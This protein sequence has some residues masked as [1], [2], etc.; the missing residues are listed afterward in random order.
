[1][2]IVGI[3][4]A[5]LRSFL[6]WNYMHILASLLFGCSFLAFGFALYFFGQWGGGDAKLLAA[7]AFLLPTT[8]KFFSK[9]LI[10]PFPLSYL[11]N[12]LYVGAGYMILY[13]FVI[14]LM[15]K[16]VITAFK[17]DVK[18]SSNFLLL[19]V[20]TIFFTF[21]FANWY[22]SSIV[23]LDATY[24]FWYAGLAASLFVV[25]WFVWKFVKTVEDVGF[26]KRIPVSKLKVGDVLVQSKQW[27]GLTAEEVR[28][29]KKSGK[30]YVVIKEGVRFGLAFPLALLFT[31]YFGDGILFFVRYFI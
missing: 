25:L 3:A 8:P 31:L 16:K 14:A 24:A 27:E 26:K 4:L 21:L 23:M 30:K 9:E 22:F 7:V 13:A 2:M 10:L 6:E 17:K 28:K 1:M 11:L 18:A 29:I 19:G 15:N 5:A 20:A 12:L